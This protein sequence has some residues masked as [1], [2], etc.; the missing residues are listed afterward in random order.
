MARDVT[1]TDTDAES[2]PGST[3][4]KP[5]AAAHKTEQNKIYKY[6]KLASTHIFN[7]FAIE[8]AGTWHEMAI[9]LTQVTGRCITTVTE[10][11]LCD[12]CVV[13]RNCIFF[14][15]EPWKGIG[16][17]HSFS[18]AFPWLSKKM[19]FLSTTQWSQSKSPLQPQF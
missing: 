5:G 14:F 7:P 15:R 17:Q 10:D 16:R 12:H 6:S 2:H 11:L 8:T 18:N 3:A 13:E 4:T 1:V 19:Q 9:E